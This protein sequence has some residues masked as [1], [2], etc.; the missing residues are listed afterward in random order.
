VSDIRALIGEKVGEPFGLFF[1][2][3]EG[4]FFPNGDEESSG[5]VVTRSGRHFDFWTAW[6]AQSKQMIL[7][8][9]HAIVPHDDWFENAEYVDAIAEAAS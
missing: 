7:E 8:H 3:G 2:T 1:C 9:W 5:C 4:R 6:D